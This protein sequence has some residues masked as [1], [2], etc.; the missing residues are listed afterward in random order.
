M[1]QFFADEAWLRLGKQAHQQIEFA[2]DTA[3]WW[4]SGRCAPTPP[5]QASVHLQ[6]T[7]G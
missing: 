1:R 2:A 3:T 6:F 4:T 7:N 5:E